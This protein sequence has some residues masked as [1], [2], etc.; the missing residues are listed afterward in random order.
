MLGD[1]GPREL[2]GNELQVV[3]CSDELVRGEVGVEE[4]LEA[5]VMTRV[6]TILEPQ[7]GLRV[8]A[9]SAGEQLTR[10]PR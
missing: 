9:V 8:L 7:G 2:G 5:R 6:P 10:S 4:A 3:R 1:L